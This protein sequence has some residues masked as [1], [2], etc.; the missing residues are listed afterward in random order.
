MKKLIAAIGIGE[1]FYLVGLAAVTAG[2]AQ[3]SL[4]AGWITLGAIMLLTSVYSYLR[5]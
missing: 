5:K 3:I 4:A 2:A 1:V